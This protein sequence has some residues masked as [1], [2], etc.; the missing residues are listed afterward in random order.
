MPRTTNTVI[1]VCEVC[2]QGKQGKR[3][4]LVWEGEGA[5]STSKTGHAEQK[6]LVA[7]NIL[8]RTLP[9]AQ[10]GSLIPTPPTALW[11]PFLHLK[12]FKKLPMLPCSPPLLSSTSSAR[13]ALLALL[14]NVLARP[15]RI[16]WLLYPGHRHAPVLVLFH[17]FIV[18]SFI[19]SKNCS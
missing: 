15:P 7:S 9:S 13:P 12:L 3:A 1:L 5:R 4:V 17:S 19:Y 11:P 6:S 8:Y 18:H 16:F 14:G 2:V 10:T